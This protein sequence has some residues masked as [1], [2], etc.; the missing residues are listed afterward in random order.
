MKISNEGL[1]FIR[2][3]EGCKLE[4]YLD[5]GGVWTIGVGHIKGVKPGQKISQLEADEMLRMDIEDHDISRFITAPTKQREFD[6]MCSL[7]FNVG[8]GGYR[9]DGTIIPGF[10]HSTV[11]KRHNLG[12]R[13]GAA[14]AFRMWNKDN[15]R[16]VKGLVNRREAERKL[17]L[18][19]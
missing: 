1:A 13:I 10:Q 2:Q 15:G 8:M 3:W 18:G 6:A 17:Y 4:A 7:A 9:K 16:I 5:T 14:N 12:N 11:L 19:L